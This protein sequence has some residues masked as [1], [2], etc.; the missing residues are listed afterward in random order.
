MGCGGSKPKGAPTSK[1]YAKSVKGSGGEDL[2]SLK[3][4]NFEKPV[5]KDAEKRAR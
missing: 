5:L 2:K 4:H 1:D 3:T